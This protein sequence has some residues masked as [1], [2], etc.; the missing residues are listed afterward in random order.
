MKGSMRRTIMRGVVAGLALAATTRVA[1]AHYYANNHPVDL[2]INAANPQPWTSPEWVYIGSAN[3]VDGVGVWDGTIIVE[4]N[5]VVTSDRIWVGAAS[6]QTSGRLIVDGG[7]WTSASVLHLAVWGPDGLGVDEAS[8]VEINNGGTLSLNGLEIAQN[9][10]AL[11]SL[12]IDDATLTNVGAGHL[13]TGTGD[14]EVTIRNGGTG[15]SGFT[16]MEAGSGHSNLSVDGAG[17]QWEG[18][19]FY[20]GG[21]A[22]TASLNITGGATVLADHFYCAR[23]TALCEVT[24]SGAGSS[25]APGYDVFIGEVGPARITVEEGGIFSVGNLGAGLDVSNTGTLIFRVGNGSR[26][27]CAGNAVIDDGATIVVKLDSGFTPTLGVPYDL[28]TASVALTADINN[29]VLDVSAIVAGY[30]AE[31]SATSTA[32]QIMFTGP[33]RGTMYFV[34]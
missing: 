20:M 31:L 6:P 22:R 10:G 33:P 28:I 32:L 9:S 2:V 16:A 14:A 34:E 21:N 30:T 26:I 24:I 17:S 1:D 15:N 3:L 11:G 25:L 23:G 27:A 8:L 29:L 4:S 5:G 12:I 19:S 18:H 13:G 7:T